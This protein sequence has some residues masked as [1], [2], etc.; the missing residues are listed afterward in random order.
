MAAA[1]HS[2]VAAY[3]APES[4]G[5]V[6]AFEEA[7]AAADAGSEWALPMLER[8]IADH[9]ASLEARDAILLAGDCN[10]YAA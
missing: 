3:T 10:Y 9:P 5:V 4:Q 6:S 8:F 1:S 2:G 7:K